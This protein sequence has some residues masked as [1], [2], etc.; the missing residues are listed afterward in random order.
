[1]ERSAAGFAAAGKCSKHILNYWHLGLLKKFCCQKDHGH[2][3]GSPAPCTL[4]IDKGHIET[5]KK[6]ITAGALA[7]P[8]SSYLFSLG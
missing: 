8:R 6:L 1:M 5:K 3:P 4:K 2:R 7:W